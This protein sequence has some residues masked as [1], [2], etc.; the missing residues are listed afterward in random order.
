MLILVKLKSNSKNVV[1]GTQPFHM[2]PN[3][4]CVFMGHCPMIYSNKFIPRKLTYFNNYLATAAMVPFLSDF[5]GSFCYSSI[6][7]YDD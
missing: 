4:I 3:V 1:M 7:R 6:N 2:F 5:S